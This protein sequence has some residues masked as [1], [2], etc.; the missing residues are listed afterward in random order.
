VKPEVLLDEPELFDRPELLLDEPELLVKPEVLLDE[1]ELFDRPE[2]PLDEPELLDRPELPFDEPAPLDAPERVVDPELPE[3]PEL[4]VGVEPSAPPPR[5][6]HAGRLLAEP[7][8]A[9]STASKPTPFDL[10][11]VRI[12]DLSARTVPLRRSVHV[13]LDTRQAPASGRSRP[14]PL[15][16]NWHIPPIASHGQ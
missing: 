4:L 12:V 16:A 3:D 6:P 11:V 1:P 13:R 14:S 2:L 5:P 8:S 10:L 7:P 15:G 9:P